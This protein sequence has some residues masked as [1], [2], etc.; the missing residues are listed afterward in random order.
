MDISKESLSE[1][2]DIVI[3]SEVIEHLV[4]YKKSIKHLSN[5][6][7]KYLIITVPSCP[8]FNSDKKM[9]HIRHFSEDEICAVL[10]E[11]NLKINKILK[12]GFPFFN[13]Y[14]HLLKR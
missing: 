4:E 12:W 7:E 6:T 14:K 1:K 3:C 2:F 8:L 9:G 10:K 13:L 11:N 5:M